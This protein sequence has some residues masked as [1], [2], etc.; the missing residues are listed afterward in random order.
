MPPK[1][2]FKEL[3]E[4]VEQE[5]SLTKTV[6]TPGAMIRE[7]KEQGRLN[8]HSLND[9]MLETTEPG[10]SGSTYHLR[11]PTVFEDLKTIYDKL[12][13][14]ILQL[15]YDDGKITEIPPDWTLIEYGHTLFDFTRG[16]SGKTHLFFFIFF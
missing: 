10:F 5:K 9:N 4:E 13:H 14:P 6:E 1:N 3:H 11:R 16:S 12:L 7:L 2:D 15:A 8:K